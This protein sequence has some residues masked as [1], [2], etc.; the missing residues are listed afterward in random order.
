MDLTIFHSA[1]IGI[2][3]TSDDPIT[4]EGSLTIYDELILTDGII[5][6]TS[7]NSIIIAS[8]ASISG[9]S[10]DSYIDGPLIKQG[11]TGG[12][13]FTFP[14]GDG[15]TYAPLE[16]SSMSDANSQ[17][18]AEYFRST[19]TNYNSVNAPLDHISAKEY[20]SLTKDAGTDNVGVTLY[21]SNAASSGIND[22]ATLEVAY[23]SSG[24][25]SWSTIENGGTTGGVGF[26]ANGSIQAKCPPPFYE[27][28]TFGTTSAALNPLPVELAHF[29]AE[30][31]RG[32][33]SLQWLT[34]SERSSSHFIVERSMDGFQF[35]EL[36]VIQA[37]GNSN[38]PT[39][40]ATT[41]QF[42]IWR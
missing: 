27:K 16:I 42:P 24:S 4:L 1:K 34:I 28:F 26:G 41:D 32:N 18:T 13:S 25:S 8:G 14:L 33:V 29:E 6:T 2:N 39:S 10:E 15:S 20:W 35:E 31:K 23:Y 17:Y 36:A 19:P 21:W 11:S 22:L 37:A 9:G 12:S 40:Y 30:P 5:T 38:I 7:T 3:A